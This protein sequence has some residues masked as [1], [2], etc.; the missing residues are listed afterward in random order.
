MRLTEYKARQERTAARVGSS[1]LSLVRPMLGETLT[2]SDVARVV[3][4]TFPAV[5][6]ARAEEAAH[7]TQFYQSQRE[8]SVGARRPELVAPPQTYRPTHLLRGLTQIGMVPGREFTSDVEAVS[9]VTR[10]V[11]S[12]ARQ[13]LVGLSLVDDEAEGWARTSGGTSACSFC[14]M[15]IGR[16]PVYKSRD[17]AAGGRSGSA[18]Y[19]N[20][21]D[22]VSVPVFNR[23]QF[24]G[25][26]EYLRA[27]ELWND[28]T[29]GKNGKDALS[30]FRTAVSSNAPGG[31][32]ASRL[33]RAA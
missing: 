24:P 13:E 28:S 14:L 19:H 6:M 3:Q 7:A 31:R 20:R 16:G 32:D 1:V 33:K 25:R 15:L 30:A 17:S 4:S 2:E 11:K 18:R 26:A 12:G 23:N 21:C 5:E 27:R 22:C 10:H 9:T 29:K 8:K